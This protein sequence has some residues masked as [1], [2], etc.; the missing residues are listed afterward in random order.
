MENVAL[1]ILGLFFLALIGL[2]IGLGGEGLLLIY[3]KLR[4]HYC[5]NC[6]Y[7]NKKNYPNLEDS[8]LWECKRAIT[9][10]YN[11]VS[12]EIYEYNHKRCSTVVGSSNCRWKREKNEQN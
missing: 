2:A 11:M 3:M 9:R 7:C 12:G 10:Q 1:V 6:V 5:H 4:G 8:N